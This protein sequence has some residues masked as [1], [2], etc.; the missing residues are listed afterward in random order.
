MIKKEYDRLSNKLGYILEKQ[1]IGRKYPNC[2]TICNCVYINKIT[3]EIRNMPP[4]LSGYNLSLHKTFTKKNIFDTN[5]WERRY[6]ITN[7]ICDQKIIDKDGF[8]YDSY[9]SF[10]ST[11]YEW[12][13][14]EEI[15]RKNKK[16]NR[17]LI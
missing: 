5:I 11:R 1:K 10:A 15:E 13:I 8:M 12:I 16:N 14:E 2:R 7:I 17:E 4:G 3:G 6:I 9:A